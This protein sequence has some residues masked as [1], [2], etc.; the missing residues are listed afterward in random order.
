[1]AVMAPL[2]GFVA[3]K[4]LTPEPDYTMTWGT[5]EGPPVGRVMFTKIEDS[6]S[7]EASQRALNYYNSKANEVV[8]IL[9]SRSPLF[10]LAPPGSLPYYKDLYPYYENLYERDYKFSNG[11]QWS[12][13]ERAERGQFVATDRETGIAIRFVKQFDIAQKVSNEVVPKREV[14]PGAD[15]TIHP[16]CR[17]GERLIVSGGRAHVYPALSIDTHSASSGKLYAGAPPIMKVIEAHIDG[18]YS[19]DADLKRLNGLID[20]WS[21]PNL[22]IRGGKATWK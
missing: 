2:A 11:K 18:V 5:M 22:P 10:G 21:S 4:K 17:P 13:E 20:D 7:L 15:N 9:E 14:F 3:A 19:S 12:V 6:S 8:G 1:M 16:N